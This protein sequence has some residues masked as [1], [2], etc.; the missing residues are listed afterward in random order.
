[1][2]LPIT[3][4]QSRAL[5]ALKAKASKTKFIVVGA[6]AVGHHV[7]LARP[8]ADVDLAIA[9]D[10][11]ELDKLLQSV[12]RKRD[13]RMAQR[14]H[15]PDNF[16]SSGESVV[17]DRVRGRAELRRVKPLNREAAG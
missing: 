15:G 16:R 12:G 13:S 1:M 3:R 9:A 10:V 17:R 14:W 7:Q 5:L 2:T 11:G 8:T 4:A 6:A